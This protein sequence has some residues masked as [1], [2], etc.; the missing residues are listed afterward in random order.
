M[1]E[2]IRA[3]GYALWAYKEVVVTMIGLGIFLRRS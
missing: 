3:A 2:K 1:S